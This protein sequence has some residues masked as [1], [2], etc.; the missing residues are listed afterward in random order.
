MKNEI[1]AHE[2]PAGIHAGRTA[3]PIA[4]NS[5]VNGLSLG[6]FGWA[7]GGKCQHGLR[8]QRGLRAVCH[9]PFAHALKEANDSFQ[10]GK[11]AI[12]V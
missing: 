8:A 3:C 1:A 11:H 7:P 2:I 6:V 12:L 5:S 9:L 4:A 10:A